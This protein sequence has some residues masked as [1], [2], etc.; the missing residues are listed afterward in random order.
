MEEQMI[1]ENIEIK[2][3]KL[4]KIS[5]V[6]F[7]LALFCLIIYLI[8]I[9]YTPFADFFNRYISSIFR[10]ILASI[11]NILPLSLSEIFLITLPIT[12]FFI[13]RYCMNRYSGSWHDVGIFCLAAL[14]VLSLFF[15]I[16][17][18]TFGTGY[19]TSELDVKLELEKSEKISKEEL[20]ST[21]DWLIGEVNARVKSIEFIEKSSSVSPY[22]VRE[23]NTILL[24]SYKKLSAKYDFLPRLTSY[25]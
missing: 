3:E 7:G 19:Y 11:T 25:I 21:A 6:F 15:S 12:L 24:E 9:F 20:S 2:K 16:F 22:S 4:P 18:L 23:I 5:Y 8:A 17:I 1:N 14:S 10:G 13:I